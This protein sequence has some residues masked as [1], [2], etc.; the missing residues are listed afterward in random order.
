MSR[1]WGIH[2]DALGLQLVDEGFISI[3]WE[4]VGDLRAFHGDREAIKDALLRAFPNQKV[5][6]IPVWAGVLLRFVHEVRLGDLVVAPYKAD[7]TLNLGVVTGEYEYHPDVEVHRSRRRV[8]WLMTGVPRSDFPQSALYEIGSAVTLFRIKRHESV[9]RDY[10]RGHGWAHEVGG[11]VPPPAPTHQG[12]EDDESPD[13]RVADGLNADRIELHTRDFVNKVLLADLSHE[14][15]EEFTADLLRA[16]GYEA[17]VT[18][19]TADGGVDVLAH[20]DP[21]GLEPPLIKVQCKHTSTTQGRPEVQ[22][23]IGTLASGEV[24]LFVTLGAFTR[25]AL[26]VERERQNLRL[27]D[28]AEV[29]Q[30]T[31]EHYADLPAR[32]RDRLPLRPVLVVDVSPERQ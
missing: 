29:T 17:R 15:F 28:G 23:L 11:M 20:R 3:G 6:A 24:G 16:L 27:F 30:L 12:G 26:A 1:M 31:L 4:E 14:E 21:L 2:N 19:Y 9:F 25:E 10:L 32:W 18:S 13:E 7:S 5:G 22:Q 8:R